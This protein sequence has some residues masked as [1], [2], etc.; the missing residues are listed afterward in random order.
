MSF[1]WPQIMRAGLGML[2]I[3]PEQFWRM[4]LKEL[5]AALGPQHR[6]DVK[7]LRELM[8]RYPDLLGT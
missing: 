5:A 4:T 2:R 3:P 7:A 6:T 1:P 8:N